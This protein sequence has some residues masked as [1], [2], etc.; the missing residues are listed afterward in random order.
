VVRGGLL[1]CCGLTSGSASARKTAA[2]IATK[3]HNNTS[4]TTTNTRSAFPPSP[5]SPPALTPRNQ[6]QRWKSTTSSQWQ[7]LQTPSITRIQPYLSE[8]VRYSNP[9]MAYSF[10]LPIFQVRR[11]W[12]GICQTS[13]RKSKRHRFTLGPYLAGVNRT[14][15][16]Q[17]QSSSAVAI[18]GQNSLTSTSH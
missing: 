4:Y 14:R 7:D 16:L 2:Q 9:S 11:S 18:D 8:T 5:L 1:C 6:K 10:R 3:T 13:A 17:A 12:P 15:R